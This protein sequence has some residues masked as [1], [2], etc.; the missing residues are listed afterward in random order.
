M[1][2][3]E[4]TFAQL[5][6]AS[7]SPDG[8]VLNALDIGLPCSGF[9]E[10]GYASNVAAL[11]AMR[12]QW[13]TSRPPPMQ[14]VNWA[15]AATAGAFHSWHIHCNGFMTFIS[16]VCG[17]KLWIIGRPHQGQEFE[18]L[19]RT[20]NFIT[21]GFKVMD[22]NEGLWTPEAVLLKPGDT[23]WVFLSVMSQEWNINYFVGS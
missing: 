2:L 16:P 13:K 23:L 14:D 10:A 12:G 15:S 6:E 3:K 4:G 9:N 8:K 19:A 22:V 5:L 11:G 7:C 20:S 17:E 21:Q 18:H 1:R